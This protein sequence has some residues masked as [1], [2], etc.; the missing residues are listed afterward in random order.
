[1]K[2][3]ISTL[4]ADSA[5][6]TYCSTYIRQVDMTA[7]KNAMSSAVKLERTVGELLKTAKAWRYLYRK[8]WTHNL[9]NEGDL[10]I[11]YQKNPFGGPCDPNLGVISD[12][13]S[14]SSYVPTEEMFSDSD[15]HNSCVST[16]EM[17]PDSDICNTYIPTKEMLSD[18]DP[19]S[20]TSPE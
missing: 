11:L 17:L 2:A 16:T 19:N 3:C 1:M 6:V 13:G 7:L 9:K 5:F 15:S 10:Q 20:S 8:L 4:S 18:S 14:D 12:S